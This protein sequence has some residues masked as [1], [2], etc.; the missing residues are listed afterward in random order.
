[1]PE[2]FDYDM[3]LGPAPATPYTPKRVI[4]LE[5]SPRAAR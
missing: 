5:S 2:G 3:W 1:V 4:S